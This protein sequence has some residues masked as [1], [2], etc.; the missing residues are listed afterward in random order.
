MTA[1]PTEK[2]QITQWLADWRGGDEA[3]QEAL[4]ASMYEELKVIAL[5]E[6]G[7]E[8]A[9]HTLQPT[10]I[11][12]EA[13]IRISSADISW[14]DRCHFLAVMTS[15]MRRVLVDHARARQRQRR[16]GDALHVTLTEDLVESS[17]EGL[18]GATSQ[19]ELMDLVRALDALREI[20]ERKADVLEYHY[21]GGMNY[22]EIAHVTDL[23]A[24]TVHREL[25]FSRSWLK[26]HLSPA[27]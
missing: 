7:R 13:L 18:G 16:G 11:I 8:R 15:T 21:F 4:I 2:E 23:S 22:D 17:P 24:A 25:R 1:G 14:S 6:F 3:A 12:N 10:A 9:N 27:M 19:P 5:R 20:D 26:N